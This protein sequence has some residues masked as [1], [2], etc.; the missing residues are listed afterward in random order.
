MEILREVY[1]KVARTNG[2]LWG[3]YRDLLA[4]G[5]KDVFLIYLVSKET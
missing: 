4:E 2:I 3:H 5:L 1:K